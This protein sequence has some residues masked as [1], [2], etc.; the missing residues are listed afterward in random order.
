M[1][2]FK[3]Q[4]RVADCLCTAST[5]KSILVECDDWDEAMWFP[6][7]KVDDASEVYSRYENENTGTLIVS[8]WIAKQKGIDECD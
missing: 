2:S 6:L 1:A 3:E 7:S 5:D 8:A 4:V